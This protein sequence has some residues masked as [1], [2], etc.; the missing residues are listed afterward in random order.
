MSARVSIHLP[1][2][3]SALGL[4]IYTSDNQLKVLP[5]RGR[6]R[7]IWFTYDGLWAI[8]WSYIGN[9]QYIDAWNVLDTGTRFQAEHEIVRLIL[10]YM[11]RWLTLIKPWEENH[12]KPI[13]SIVISPDSPT[14]ILWKRHDNI[15]MMRLSRPGPPAPNLPGLYLPNLQALVILS[16]K[17]DAEETIIWIKSETKR[18]NLKPYRVSV[19]NVVRLKRISGQLRWVHDSRAIDLDH[20]LRK[21]SKCGVSVEEDTSVVG[22]VKVVVA[23]H[24]GKVEK[25][26]FNL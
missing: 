11:N 20:N 6:V 13:Q 21:P 9:I 25:K 12:K 5:A 18:Q 14:C 4:I 23:H 7:N 24:D 17:S 22:L 15:S 2:S 26:P 10:N 16:K 19:I 8:A 3:L 1:P